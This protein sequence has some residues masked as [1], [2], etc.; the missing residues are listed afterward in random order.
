MYENYSSDVS[1]DN[2][3]L[4][5]DND[6]LSD[7]DAIEMD[8]AFLASL[9]T[10]D[11]ALSRAGIKD[12]EN[13]LQAMKWTPLSSQYETNIPSY[14]G[15]GTEEARPVGE[16]LDVWRS[17]I[18]TLF[19]FVPKSFWVMI[20]AETNR[21]GLQQVDKRA[22]KMFAWQNEHRRE[23]VKK[24]ARRLK[25]QQ[26]YAPHEVMHVVG[27]LVARMLC[28]QKRSFAAHWSMV[29]D[30]AVLAGRFGR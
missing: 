9:Q 25:A 15:L 16:L 10:G 20:A 7:S 17:P 22:Q 12:R 6:V 4:D 28:P 23:T 27:L 8:A 1:D 13:A 19:Y 24:I 3:I 30:G 21:Y 18:L 29:E 14:P 26:S 2:G 11:S 5:G